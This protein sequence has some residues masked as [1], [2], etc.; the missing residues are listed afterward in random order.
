MTNPSQQLKQLKQLPILKLSHHSIMRG[1]FVLCED[2]NLTLIQ[3]EICHL[4]GA[5]GAGKTSLLMQLAGLIP[6]HIETDSDKQPA[7]SVQYFGVDGLPVQPVYVS[8]QL[9]IHTD[10]TVEQNL[11]FLLELY[12]ITPQAEELAQALDWVGLQGY[13]QIACNELSAGQTRRVNLARLWL[14]GVD[15]SPLWLLDEPFTALDVA[16]ITRLQA[17]IRDFAKAGGAVLMTSHQA[18]SIAD[19][20]L[21]LAVGLDSGQNLGVNS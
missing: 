14:M 8:H 2:V 12:G 4:V 20:V 16:M 5:N 13:E 11:Q 17:R 1:E 6:I 9:G 10:L 3:G 7:N 19:K 21:D 15:N 18:V